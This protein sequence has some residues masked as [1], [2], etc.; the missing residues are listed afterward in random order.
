M[1]TCPAGT[2]TCPLC[3][4]TTRGRTPLSAVCGLGWVLLPPRPHVTM[5]PWAPNLCF[6]RGA[7]PTHAS[8]AGVLRASGPSARR[9]PFPPPRAQLR[10]VQ[11]V[12]FPTGSSKQPHTSRGCRGSPRG[13]SG[14]HMGATALW[15]RRWLPGRQGPVENPGFPGSF[16]RPQMC[17]RH[18]CRSQEQS[19]AFC[20][21]PQRL[22]GSARARAP[23]LRLGAP[24]SPAP[25]CR[26]HS[27]RPTA[28]WTASQLC[29]GDDGAAGPAARPP[30]PPRPPQPPPAAPSCPSYLVPWDGRDAWRAAPGRP[31]RPAAE[32]GGN[33][34]LVQPDSATQ[35]RNSR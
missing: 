1:S 16:K 30:R 17:A 10:A 29:R 24:W 18:H 13:F 23:A 25:E 12:A 8:D 6:P 35:P 7:G 15:D 2:V 14:R 32:C 21:A 19:V 11:S 22:P 28:G 27:Q 9:R 4:V 5:T 26:R 34:C 20:E 31:P 33:L 3:H